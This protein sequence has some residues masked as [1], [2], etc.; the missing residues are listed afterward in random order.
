[1]VQPPYVIGGLLMI[2]GYVWAAIRREK[3]RMPPES[4]EFLRKEQ[5]NRLRRMLVTYKAR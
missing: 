4:V 1:M 3:R 5:M 2:A